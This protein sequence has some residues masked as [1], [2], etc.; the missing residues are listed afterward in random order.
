VRPRPSAFR[1][2][3]SFTLVQHA[4][5]PPGLTGVCAH[6]LVPLYMAEPLFQALVK[7]AFDILDTDKSGTVTVDDIRGLY[8]ATRHPDVLRGTRTIDD[9]LEEILGHFELGGEAKVRIRGG[10]GCCEPRPSRLCPFAFSSPSIRTA[11]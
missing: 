11:W 10:A 2:L 1:P 5:W 7:M 6:Y 4:I 8:D 9:V 3:R